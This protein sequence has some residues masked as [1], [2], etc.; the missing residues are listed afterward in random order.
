[1]S[2]NLAVSIMKAAITDERLKALIDEHIDQ[3]TSIVATYL[4][5]RHPKLEVSPGLPG[6]GQLTVGE[7]LTLE[8]VQGTVSISGSRTSRTAQYMEDLSQEVSAFLKLVADQLFTWQV[9]QALKASAT[10]S[11]KQTSDVEND[12]AVQR[13]TVYAIQVNGVRAR[14]FVLPNGRAHVFVDT[15]T[16]VAA[17]AVTLQLLQQIQAR[18][19]PLQMI[20]EVEQHRDDVSHVHVHQ[21]QQMGG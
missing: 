4:H 5:R 13:A 16:F 3:V 6:T 14:V 19:L 1:M 9:E 2:C 18:G 21:A 8:I 15:G 7:G 10:V 11:S 17:K 20:G 12:G